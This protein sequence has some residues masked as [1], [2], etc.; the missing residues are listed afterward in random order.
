MNV[1]VVT[2]VTLPPKGF[3]AREGQLVCLGSLLGHEIVAIGKLHL[4][5][6]ADLDYLG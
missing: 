1:L 5:I 4:A 2:E 6:L 3:V